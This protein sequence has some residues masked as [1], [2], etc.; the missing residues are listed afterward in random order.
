M[1]S[2]S[3]QESEIINLKYFSDLKNK[4]ISKILKIKE[5]S[6]SSAISK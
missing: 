1:K 2:L 5:K 4:E 3:K 6:V